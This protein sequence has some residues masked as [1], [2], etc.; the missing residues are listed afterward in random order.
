MCALRSHYFEQRQQAGRAGRRAQGSLAV[1]VADNLP[2]DQHF[3]SNPDEV[4][5]APMPDLVVDLDNEV[6]LE[7]H[8]QCAANDMPISLQSD[9]QYFG[10]NVHAARFKRMCEQKLLQDKEGWYLTHP[11]YKPRPSV[12]VP[13]RGTQEA[14]YTVLDVTNATV[15]GKVTI[16]EE[17]ELSRALFEV[18]KV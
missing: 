3:V 14:K 11:K 4:F 8:L 7:G 9:V 12:L 15:S 16:L 6:I 17:L 2:I 13:I 5:D 1:Y 18:S 10:G